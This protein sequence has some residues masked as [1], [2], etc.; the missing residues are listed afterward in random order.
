[1]RISLNKKVGKVYDSGTS[2]G[3]ET[4]SN[5]FL[6]SQ[7]GERIKEMLQTIY[8]EGIKR[9]LSIEEIEKLSDEAWQKAVAEAKA[10]A[11]RDSGTA[12]S[13]EERDF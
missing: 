2:M 10:E 1:M 13:N 6:S 8:D 12:Q 5:K 3:E 7:A 11:N 9:G 4:I